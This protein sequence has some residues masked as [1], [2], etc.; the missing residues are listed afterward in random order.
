MECRDFST[1]RETAAQIYREA[2]S[3]LRKD[4]YFPPATGGGRENQANPTQA[5]MLAS[6]EADGSVFP[7][8]ER[9]AF[10]MGRGSCD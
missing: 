10:S 4:D 3:Q 8:A 5:Y 2:C 7:G 1:V 9:S 6:L